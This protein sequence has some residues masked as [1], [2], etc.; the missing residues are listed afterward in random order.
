M[1]KCIVTHFAPTPSEKCTPVQKPNRMH[2]HGGLCHPKEQRCQNHHC[3]GEVCRSRGADI[4]QDGTG[5]LPVLKM[6]VPNNSQPVPYRPMLGGLSIKKSR[7]P[8]TV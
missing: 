8:R 1:Y 7:G 6:E 2:R 4:A 5:F 3:A